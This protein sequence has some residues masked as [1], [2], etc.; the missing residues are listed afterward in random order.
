M[1]LSP[2]GDKNRGVAGFANEAIDTS[3][4]ECECLASESRLIVALAEEVGI[5]KRRQERIAEGDSSQE[6]ADENQ[7]FGVGDDAHGTI[8]VGCPMCQK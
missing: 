8:V 6:N 4:G 2:N 5:D 3:I 7:E 1:Y